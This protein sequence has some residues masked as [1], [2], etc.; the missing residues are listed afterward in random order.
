[1]PT[2]YDAALE[3]A[4]PTSKH[5]TPEGHR[6]MLILRKAMLDAGFSPIR[7]EWWHYDGPHCDAYDLLDIHL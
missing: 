1:M 7:T 2:A 4:S 3:T 6:N 5:H